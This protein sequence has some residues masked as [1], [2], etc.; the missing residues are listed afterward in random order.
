MR[1]SLLR[2]IFLCFLVLITQGF[3]R[4]Q[5]MRGSNIT[6]PEKGFMDSI[7]FY[8]FDY[9]YFLERI[10]GISVVH[11]KADRNTTDAH[12]TDIINFNFEDILEVF[13]SMAVNES[14]S[15]KNL[16]IEGHGEEWKLIKRVVQEDGE[17]WTASFKNSSLSYNYA[18]GSIYEGGYSLYIMALHNKLKK[19]EILANYIQ[20]KLPHQETE[21]LVGINMY[22]TPQGEKQAFEVHMDYMDGLILQVAGCKRWRVYNPESYPESLRG[23]APIKG[24]MI[25]PD[26]KHIDLMS[27]EEYELRQGDVLYIPKGTL[28]EAATNCTIDDNVTDQKIG[29]NKSKPQIPSVHLTIGIEDPSLMKNQYPDL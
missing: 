2:V 12:Y 29:N 10:F 24:N 7:F 13:R 4:K 17:Y 1:R 25:K 26:Q 22:L 28:H 16:V 27:F 21:Y 18:M 15:I 11:L 20:S 23:V 19:M 8:P 3:E 5:R 9:E 14:T 6:I